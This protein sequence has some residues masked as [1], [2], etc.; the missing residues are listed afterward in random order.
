MGDLG[1]FQCKGCCGHRPSRE[2]ASSRIGGGREVPGMWGGDGQ[3]GARRTVGLLRVQLP[4]RLATSRGRP[5]F[6]Q[7]PFPPQTQEAPLGS[8]YTYTWE[9]GL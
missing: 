4:Q 2:Q 5:L 9:D 3:Q 6:V 1:P 7:K 8:P